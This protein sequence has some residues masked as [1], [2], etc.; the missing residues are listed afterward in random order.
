M[1]SIDAD[2]VQTYSYT[3]AQVE[4][5]DQLGRT[6]SVSAHERTALAVWP[7]GGLESHDAAG[8][9]TVA[10]GPGLIHIKEGWHAEF[11]ER[12]KAMLDSDFDYEAAKRALSVNRDVARCAD[13]APR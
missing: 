4:V 9:R 2:I 1:A 5:V 3:S 13:P 8:L 7:A 10:G 6:T 12:R 11:V